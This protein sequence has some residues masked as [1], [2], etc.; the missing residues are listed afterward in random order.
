MLEHDMLPLGVNVLLQFPL[1]FYGLCVPKQEVENSAFLFLFEKRIFS[2]KSQSNHI[3]E[4][5]KIN[6]KFLSTKPS[7]NKQQKTPTQLKTYSPC[8]THEQANNTPS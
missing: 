3:Q 4:P 5:S 8:L 7:Y 6:L 2:R 1:R